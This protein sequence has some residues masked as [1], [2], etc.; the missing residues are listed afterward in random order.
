MATQP[1]ID[2]III[3]AKDVKAAA[4]SF[5]KEFGLAAY[6]GGKHDGWGTENYI[7]P[8]GEGYIEIAAVF[9][10]KAADTCDWGRK[11]TE[12]ADGLSSSKPWTLVTFAVETPEG[13]AA[14]AERLK[15]DTA[16]M[17]RFR[18]DGTNITWRVAAMSRF[19]EP[20]RDPKPFFITWDDV[21][22][23]PDKLPADHKVKPERIEYV[24][25]AGDKAA[26]QEWVG[27]QY[28]DGLPISAGMVC[29]QGSFLQFWRNLDD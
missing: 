26:M 9:D 23:R 2:H 10:Q 13:A 17:R 25:V 16:P 3:A 4:D 21:K 24:E 12:A 20:D 22:T 8:L 7:I 15:A 18:P 29:N 19:M 11:I 5:C 1:R 28:Y 6:V 14:T 27:S